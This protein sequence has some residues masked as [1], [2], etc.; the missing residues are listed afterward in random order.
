MAI[1]E[2]DH[3]GISVEHERQLPR[4]RRIEGQVRGLQQMV[5]DKRYCIDIGHQIDAVIAA[6]RRV[7]S[8]MVR[9]HIEA[10]IQASVASDMPEKKRREFAD[11]IATLMSRS[12]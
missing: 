11:E 12:G 8:D 1:S 3:G 5:T 10:L 9:D 4:L 6:L 7:Q 2:D